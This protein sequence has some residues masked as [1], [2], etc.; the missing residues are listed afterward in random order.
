[1]REQ[2]VAVLRALE[3]YRD[4]H[5]R[6][7]DGLLRVLGLSPLEQA[8]RQE[9]DVHA[10]LLVEGAGTAAQAIEF[11]VQDPQILEGLHG[12]RGFDVTAGDDALGTCDAIQFQIVH[13]Q[14]SWSGEVEAPLLDHQ[15]YVQLLDTGTLDTD[16]GRPTL[17]EMDQPVAPAQVEER[18]FPAVDVAGRP[19]DV[20]GGGHPI[21]CP[22]SRR[23]NRQGFALLGL[24]RSPPWV[25]PRAHEAQ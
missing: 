11:A 14:T 10:L 9:Q 15:P 7:L 22:A 1:M 21:R 24:H 3:H 16:A 19:T 23:S 17:V 20:L 13:G 8:E 2:A 5:Q 6:A 18:P 25:T 4:E 12:R